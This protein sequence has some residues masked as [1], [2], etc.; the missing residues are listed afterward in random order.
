MPVYQTVLILT[1]VLAHNF[2]LLILYLGCKTKKKS[3]PFGYLLQLLVLEHEATFRPLNYFRFLRYH[4]S[5]I[6]PLASSTCLL[7]LGSSEGIIRALW[8]RSS[9]NT[10]RSP[11]INT[12]TRCYQC[13]NIQTLDYFPQLPK[14]KDFWSTILRIKG[15]LLFFSGIINHINYTKI[16]TNFK[17]STH[18][19]K[20]EL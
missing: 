6:L 10:R 8:A 9:D 1:K 20:L 18:L 17:N 5:Y 19:L 2:S 3:I 11:R 14:T 12:C 15:I 13:Q 16:G 7:I 4:Y